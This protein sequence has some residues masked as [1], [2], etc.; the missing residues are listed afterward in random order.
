[1]AR[2]KNTERKTGLTL[3][4][5]KNVNVH[6]IDLLD[7]GKVQQLCEQKGK[8]VH[9]RIQV[10]TCLRCICL[11]IQMCICA[12][13]D[14]SCLYVVDRE[15]AI[16]EGSNVAEKAS[17]SSLSEFTNTPE[18]SP[19]SDAEERDANSFVVDVDCEVHTSCVGPV[20]TSLYKP[21]AHGAAYFGRKSGMAHTKQTA[22]KMGVAICPKAAKFPKKTLAKK[23]DGQ[24]G[25]KGAHTK[26]LVAKTA[27]LGRVASDK[28]R[29][30]PAKCSDPATGRRHCYRPG[31]RSLREIWYYQ[32]RVRLLCSKL[33]F[34]YIIREICHHDLNKPD[35]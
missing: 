20:S 26:Q 15:N 29:V 14:H 4:S 13:I 9:F 7:M 23:P 27:H 25:G 22:K 31:T 2:T 33:A 19:V 12:F 18:Y 17:L 32:K 35:I 21:L 6:G 3:N 24:N 5:F 30:M 10:H 1:M 28:C 16:L 8:N 11:R 34:S